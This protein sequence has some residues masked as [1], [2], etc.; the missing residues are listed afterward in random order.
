MELTCRR[1]TRNEQVILIIQYSCYWGVMNVYHT[2]LFKNMDQMLNLQKT[3]H[4]LPAKMKMSRWVQID[5]PTNVPWGWLIDCWDMN[6][7]SRDIYN[8]KIPEKTFRTVA[9][10]YNKY[11]NERNKSR[12]NAIFM[13]HL[14][15]FFWYKRFFLMNES[16]SIMTQLNRCNLFGQYNLNNIISN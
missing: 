16:A 8:V 7:T 9:Q 13:Y 15:I 14:A 11:Q 2:A 5:R 10:V 3:F 6:S 12:C 1:R 4:N